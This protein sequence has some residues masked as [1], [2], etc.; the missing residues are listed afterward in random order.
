[1]IVSALLCLPRDAAPLF[2]VQISK[3]SANRITRRLVANRLEE[4]ATNN[5]EG[6]VC[7]DRLPERVYTPKGLLDSAERLNAHLPARFQLD[8][9]SEPRR[10]A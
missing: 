9:G 1:L 7:G 2:D 3:A 4:S 5:L 6:F 8:S 10:T